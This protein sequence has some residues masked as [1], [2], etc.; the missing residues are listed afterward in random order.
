MLVHVQTIF[1]CSFS[2]RHLSILRGHSGSKD[3]YPRFHPFPFLTILILEKEPVFPFFNV[4]CQITIG[5]IFITS[6]VWRSPWLEIEPGTSCTRC[7][8]STTRLSRRRWFFVVKSSYF[9]NI[10]LV[11][12]LQ[13]LKIEGLQKRPISNLIWI[14]WIHVAAIPTLSQEIIKAYHRT[15]SRWLENCGSSW[16][17]KISLYR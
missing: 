9:T 15:S 2:V 5:T 14:W 3:F 1:K 8:H 12:Y 13:I 7:Q 11:I 6:L 17:H 10:C 16:R 4:E